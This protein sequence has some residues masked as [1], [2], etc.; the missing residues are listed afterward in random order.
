MLVVVI[1]SFMSYH[2]GDFSLEVV[3]ALVILLSSWYAGCLQGLIVTI[4]SGVGIVL[5]YYFFNVQSVAMHY[6][7]MGLEIVVLTTISL[8]SAALRDHHLKAEY[9]ASYDLLTGVSNRNSK[10]W[11][12]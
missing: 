8:L 7:N 3:Y 11:K 9:M 2:T 4:F 6:A 10:D 12:D 1:V 5:S